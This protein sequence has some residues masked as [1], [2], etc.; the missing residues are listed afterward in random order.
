MSGSWHRANNDALGPE[1][2]YLTARLPAPLGLA[3]LGLLHLIR[4]WCS[5]RRTT[6]LTPETVAQLGRVGGVGVRTAQRLVGALV[7]AGCLTL[8]EEGY[9]LRDAAVVAP[10]AQPQPETGATA[11]QRRWRAGQQQKKASTGPS[12]EASTVDGSVDGGAST[13]ETGGVT[14]VDGGASTEAS[15]SGHV[16]VPAQAHVHAGGEPPE[17]PAAAPPAPKKT[18]TKAPRSLP[19]RKTLAEAYAAGISQATG[20]PCSPPSERWA[21]D[22]LEAMATTHAAGR[23]GAELLGWLTR[24]ASA[25]AADKREDRWT[26]DKGFPTKLARAWLDGGNAPPPDHGPPPPRSGPKVRATPPPERNWLAD[27]EPLPPPTGDLRRDLTAG[28]FALPSDLHE[29]AQ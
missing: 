6:S 3:A 18:R 21:L 24:T 11:R 16:H 7:N 8:S 1:T 13:A 29:A 4:C 9:D 5:E 15:T 28:L 19:P 23:L 17:P 2:A 26:V 12:T 27:D 22:D 14:G 20:R 25:F 10:Q